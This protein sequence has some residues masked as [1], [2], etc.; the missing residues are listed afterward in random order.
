MSNLTTERLY[1]LL[2]AIY[3]QRDVEIGEPLRALLA[4]MEQELVAIEEDL[5]GLYDN[6][7][8]ETC[9]EWVVPYIGDLVGV[10]GLTGETS[11]LFSQRAH[12][13]N[14]I[15]YRRRKGVPAVLERVAEEMTG[16]KARAVEYFELLYSTQH[17]DNVRLGKGGTLSLRDEFVLA[18]L[19]TALD[20]AASLLDVRRI[21][22]QQGK[23]NI[24]N[25]GLFLWRLQSYPITCSEP[26][27]VENQDNCYTF[28]PLGVDTPLFNQPQPKT[29]LTER[30]EEIKVPALLSR[31]V[32]RED[33]KRYRDMQK[34]IYFGSQPVFKIIVGD[35]QI[36]AK[37]IWI[38]DLTD[39][40]VSQPSGGSFQVVVDP[41][42][43]RFAFYGAPSGEVRVSYSY[44]FSANIGGGPYDRRE[45]LAV[46][47][48]KSWVASV[49][50][51]QSVNPENR[52]F[53]NLETALTA[54]AAQWQDGIIQI[55]DNSTYDLS[56]LSIDLSGKRPGLGHRFGH[57]FKQ[58]APSPAD[59]SPNSRGGT[60]N[61]PSPTVGRGGWG[62]RAGRNDDQGQR[63]L[64]IEAADGVR[65]CVTGGLR[66]LGN[67]EES[68]LTLNGLLI[69]G[70]IE[71]NGSLDLIVNHST[72]MP[73]GIKNVTG[74]TLSLLVTVT[75]SIIGSLTLPDGMAG[76]V[77]RDSI[78]ELTPAAQ[79]ALNS[80]SQRRVAL[81]STS[82]SD[83][84][85]LTA[86]SPTV[87]VTIGAE[88]PY[89]A[90]LAAVP[91]TLAQARD[92]L[93]AAIR[94]AHDSPAFTNTHVVTDRN[95]LIV[96]P[97][98]ASPIKIEPYAADRTAIELEVDPLTAELRPVTMSEQL[99]RWLTLSE[100]SPK[101]K[102][103]LDRTAAND[104]E[105]TPK[106]RT[107]TQARDALRKAIH[108]ISDEPCFGETLV[109]IVENKLVII[110]GVPALPLVFSATESDQTTLAELGLVK[111]EQK[112]ISP[113]DLSQ[114]VVYAPPTT[115]ERVT[116]FGAMNVTQ[117]TASEVIFT[118]PVT[119]QQRQV[120]YVRFSYVPSGSETPQRY[121]CQPDFAVANAIEE[122]KKE[123]PDLNPK[124]Q[125]KIREKIQL[126]VQ[127]SF[128]STQY[129]EPGYAQ[130][131]QQC[132]PEIASG[133]EN[134]S[135]MG[136]FQHLLQPQRVANLKASLDEYLPI[137]LEAG[138]FYVT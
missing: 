102:V 107:L 97:G 31:Q 101:L 10:R 66:V 42:L 57:L 105:L 41:E 56:N 127:P 124:E 93:Q 74:D 48:Q 120:G 76:L 86:V 136:A 58:P 23:H 130:L 77:V 15:A 111:Q 55:T 99:S 14:A 38:S 113:A 44:G 121:R 8:I 24:R 12:V 92:L 39:W 2:P 137:G 65:P 25:V 132:A 123:N 83:F 69:E 115:L 114:Q 112:H 109:A 134:E 47:S 33:L 118:E 88:G 100:A 36:Q 60:R 110:P 68:R 131:S 27:K 106:P 98:E 20:T 103:T 6:W 95:R 54:W 37:D 90:R 29:A 46:P 21:A 22:T 61:S 19:N 129:G 89:P 59:P 75:N 63:Q 64:V 85:T 117:L 72:L 126:Q 119:V 128:T 30:T 116:V 122:A 49:S 71:I 45:T 3:R 7:F 16:W 18:Q 79:S 133:A 40:E 78:V 9:Q 138:I 81:V 70:G 104:I 125:Y 84:P 53:S 108:G 1:N 32:I 96:L 26:G 82:L 11:H 34:S 13:A 17:L 135:E 35:D 5:G 4:V 87:H 43:G 51:S 73:Q 52:E 67:G 50:K 28:H 94:Q 80:F 91:K 62:V